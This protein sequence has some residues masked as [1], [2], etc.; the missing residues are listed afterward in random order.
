MWGV[1]VV[2]WGWRPCGVDSHLRPSL[3]PV[4]HLF[5]LQDFLLVLQF[6]V[7]PADTTLARRQ[8]SPIDSHVAMFRG[9]RLADS[10]SSSYLSIVRLSFSVFALRDRRKKLAPQ[11]TLLHAHTHTMGSRCDPSL[12]Q[13]MTF[14]DHCSRLRHHGGIAAEFPAETFRSRLNVLDDLGA[15]SHHFHLDTR[16]YRYSA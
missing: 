15:D 12:N 5:F 9:C 11:N 13:S 3:P 1:R 2:L 10:S 4:N 14:S 16:I 7:V 6:S 8:V